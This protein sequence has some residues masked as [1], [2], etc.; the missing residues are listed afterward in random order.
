[1]EREIFGGEICWSKIFLKSEKEI[2]Q[3]WL[4]LLF[5]KAEFDS[6][7]KNKKTF[8]IPLISPLSTSSQP[9][10]IIDFLGGIWKSCR[11]RGGG[12]IV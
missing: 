2:L 11:M 9:P 1:M 8:I 3:K 7:L 6:A 10:L 12:E 4:N 5:L